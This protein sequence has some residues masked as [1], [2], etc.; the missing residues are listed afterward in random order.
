M[1]AMAAIGVGTA[2]V[3]GIHPTIHLLALPLPLLIA[4]TGAASLA[5][6]G[7][8]LTVFLRDVDYA[9]NFMA[10]LLLFS[11]PI[12]YPRSNFGES[13]WLVDANPLAATTEAVRD[14]I[15]RG[16]WPDWE[17]MSIHLVVA[18]AVLTVAIAYIRSVEHRMPDLV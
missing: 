1:L 11:A 12:M 13:Q 5:I 16:R 7:A 15:L 18:V 4:A 10:Q 8:T 6:F 2:W 3:Q 17:L 9:S 14:V